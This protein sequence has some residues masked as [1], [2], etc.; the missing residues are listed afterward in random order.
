MRFITR[1]TVL[2]FVFF[3]GG[4]WAQLCPFDAADDYQ[5]A[6]CLIRP[7]TR[8]G[9]VGQAPEALPTVLKDL[10]GKPLAIDSVKL[11]QYL[12]ESGI[13]ESAIGGAAHQDLMKARFF[14]IHDTSWPE[15]QAAD[16][17]ANMNEPTWG[18][19]KLSQWLSSNAPTHVYV[20]RV[21]DSATKAD[22]SNRVRATIYEYG[23]DIADA[24]QRRQARQQRSGLFVHV[25]LVQPRRKSNARTFFDA[26]PSP[27][28]TPPQMDRLALLYVVASY[29]SKRW[30]LPAYHAAIDAT[31]A[32][33]H[34]DP[35]NF[36]MTSWLNSVGRLLN[37]LHH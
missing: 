31:M 11:R 16:F 10:I 5:L 28:F 21:G 8:G 6:R 19:N 9:N 30:L 20:G 27:G 22:F 33:A 24:A 18:G 32:G 29:R 4:L 2:V 13:H 35:Q 1:L 15:V 3:S 37:T 34:D 14:V 26:A 25:E 23:M 36:D 12:S 7:V 17:P